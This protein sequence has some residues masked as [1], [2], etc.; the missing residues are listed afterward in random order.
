MFPGTE[1]SIRI[2]RKYA[3]PGAIGA[4]AASGM[5]GEQ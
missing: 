3:V 4:G 2:L 1:D 5:Q